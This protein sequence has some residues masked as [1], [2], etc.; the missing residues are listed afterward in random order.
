MADKVRKG[1][2]NSV[3]IGFRLLDEAIVY[4]L[5]TPKYTNDLF[6]T[7]TLSYKKTIGNISKGTLK[8]KIGFQIEHSAP[9][10]DCRRELRV[11]FG[12]YN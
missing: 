9:K 7:C 4:L 10:P 1:L 6:M 3:V 11:H 2:K 8:S 5:D 12:L